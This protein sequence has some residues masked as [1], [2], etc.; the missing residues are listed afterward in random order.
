MT[1]WEAAQ[2]GVIQGITE[3]LPISS[4][5]HL[6]VAQHIMDISRTGI[7]FEVVV[8]LGTLF[9]ILVVFYKDI[10][11]IVFSLF[12]PAS[13]NLIK[14]VVIGTIPII[15]LGLLLK[16]YIESLFHNTIVVGI[17]FL[18]TGIILILTQ[19][20]KPVKQH[21]DGKKS[22]LIGL[23]QCIALLPGVSRSGITIGSGMMLG[24]LPFEAARF[25]FFLAI[26]ALIGSGLITFGDYISSGESTESISVIVVGFF[27]SFVV[28]MLALKALLTVLSKGKFHWFGIYCVVMGIITL[29][30]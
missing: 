20:F 12:S 6:V 27:T 15:I 4:S 21:L 23:C 1:T 3:F 7:L 30:L 26:P 2:L 8:H 25:S 13:K 9:S 24:I 17:G 29:G 19:I 14:N 11:E 28:G 22:L 18:F 10:K 16:P 5:G